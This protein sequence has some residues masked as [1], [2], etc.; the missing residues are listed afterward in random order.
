MSLTLNVKIKIK[1][2]KFNAKIIYKKVIWS[3]NKRN[4]KDHRMKISNLSMSL[5]INC[6]VKGFFI[7]FNLILAF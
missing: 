6:D 7:L 4:K 1:S 2:L 3:R 5:M